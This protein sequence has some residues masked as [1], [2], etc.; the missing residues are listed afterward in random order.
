[1]RATTSRAP[2]AR[3]DSREGSPAI[4]KAVER[5]GGRKRQGRER[6]RRR[7][8]GN[9]QGTVLHQNKLW[10][11][12]EGVQTAE[13][14]RQGPW[15]TGRGAPGSGANGGSGR[16]GTGGRHSIRCNRLAAKIRVPF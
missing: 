11:P 12:A 6:G 5:P 10:G 7:R 9:L 14:G 8:C 3:G 1:M 13:G 4:D 16:R 15:R 2:D